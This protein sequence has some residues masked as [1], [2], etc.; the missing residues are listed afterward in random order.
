M[1]KIQEAVSKGQSLFFVD[2]QHNS[3]DKISYNIVYK[4]DKIIIFV[5]EKF[6]N[7]V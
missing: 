1:K 7:K 5:Y 6:N 4:P 2:Y 3:V